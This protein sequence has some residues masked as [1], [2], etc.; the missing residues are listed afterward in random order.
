MI[1][2]EAPVIG[3]DGPQ[4]RELTLSR[5]G[6]VH[7]L[8][9]D[10]AGHVAERYGL[11]V[12]AVWLLDLEVP[13]GRVAPPGVN[14]VMKRI[15][16]EVQAAQDGVFSQVLARSGRAQWEL[17]QWSQQWGSTLGRLMTEAQQGSLWEAAVATAGTLG[18][19]AMRVEQGRD[20]LE[21]LSG[22]P[23]DREGWFGSMAWSLELSL[24]RHVRE[25]HHWALDDVEPSVAF[26][27]GGEPKFWPETRMA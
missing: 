19:L 25:R 1:T 3:P 15:L 7:W 23:V 4:A 10:V 18:A 22:V 20:R 8:V 2:I 14:K 6:L 21:E 9:A 27:L 17:P 11:A 16:V 12:D 13:A 24:R 5:S 26:E